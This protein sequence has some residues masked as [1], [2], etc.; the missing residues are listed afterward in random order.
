MRNT[1][2]NHLYRSHLQGVFRGG[3]GEGDGVVFKEIS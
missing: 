1:W 3:R 2:Q